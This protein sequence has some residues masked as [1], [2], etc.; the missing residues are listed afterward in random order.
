MNDQRLTKTK[1]WLK[2][3]RS[4]RIDL[5][6]SVVVSRPPRE[7]PQFHESTKT[8]VVSAH[9]A[10]IALKGKVAP[11]QRLLLQNT[12]GGERQECHVVYV[13]N[14]LIGPPTVAV[15]FTRPAPGFWHI[16]FPPADWTTNA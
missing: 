14:E 4:Q 9:G 7:G 2:S 6:V 15:E 13:N 16:A 5:D 3:R 12:G 8:L 1:P 10:L 11:K